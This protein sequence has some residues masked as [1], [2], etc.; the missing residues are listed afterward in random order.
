MLKGLDPQTITAVCVLAG[1]VWFI[2]HL[3]LAPIKE[4]QKLFEERLDKL[5]DGQNKLE[6]G[7]ARL[8]AKLD[9]LLKDRKQP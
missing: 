5:E 9:Q 4:K 8:E 2:F 3:L 7:Q 1:S 6:A